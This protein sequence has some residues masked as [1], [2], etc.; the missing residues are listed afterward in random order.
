MEDIAMSC[1]FLLKFKTDLSRLRDEKR[2]LR[3]QNLSEL[4]SGTKSKINENH[5]EIEYKQIILQ[6]FQEGI[7]N[8]NEELKNI[9]NKDNEI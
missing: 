8:Q 3:G 7:I 5:R 4:D 1:V 9:M 2:I 6:T